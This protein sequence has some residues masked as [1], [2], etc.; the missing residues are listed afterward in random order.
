MIDLVDGDF[1]SSSSVDASEKGKYELIEE[2]REDCSM[3]G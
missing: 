1:P 3:L 2:E